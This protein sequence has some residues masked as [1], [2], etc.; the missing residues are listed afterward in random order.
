[1]TKKSFNFSR[2]NIRKLTTPINGRIQYSDTK[3][4]GLKLIVSSSGTKTYLY[5][6]K[7]N[8]RT[9]KITIGRT[10]DI[11]LQY[12]RNK[13]A[14]HR[15]D[16][17]N[18]IDPNL[19]NSCSKLT[20]TT[21]KQCLEDYLSIHNK[22]SPNTASQYRREVSRL[23]SAWYNKPLAQ[24]SRSDVACRHRE[25]SKKTPA[26]ANRVMRVLRA[27][28][29]FANQEYEDEKGKGLFPDN[30]VHRLSHQRLWNQI[31][32]RTGVI[33]QHQLKEWLEATEELPKLTR[34]GAIQR[35]YL[36]FV[37]FTGFRRSEALTLKWKDIDFEDKSINLPKTKNGQPLV[38]PMSSYIFELLVRR[39][40]SHENEY[41][42][43]GCYGNDHLI[44]PKKGIIKITSITGIQF[45]LHD[46]RRTFITI[47]ESLDI[48]PYTVK[49]LVNH[50]TKNDVTAGYIVWN[51]ER[52]RKPI[53][54][55]TDFILVSSEQK[56]N[57]INLNSHKKISN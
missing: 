35:D 11:S 56:S 31:R 12:A 21:L 4:K 49:R 57:T 47:A 50:S 16:L 39:F 32:R 7:L 9:K 30:P 6:G 10:T 26:A 46:L 52:L 19:Q 28:F 51:P 44:E 5:Q 17:C 34:F 20:E 1:M 29:N 24:I 22:L 38:L 53:Q 54:R 37:L 13:A 8:K 27:L 3:T 33:K 18:G 40:H 14:E 45:T 43:S 42:F 55:I 48:S 36:Q 25:I 41:V 15:L 23:L 2:D